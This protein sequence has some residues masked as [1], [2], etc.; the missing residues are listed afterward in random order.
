MENARLTRRVKLDEFNPDD[1]ELER[2]LSL[3]PRDGLSAAMRKRIAADL[4]SH[5]EVLVHIADYIPG[6][7]AEDIIRELNAR[8]RYLRAI[9]DRALV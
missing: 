8:V 1:P 9:A 4:R 5:A 3:P 7:H 2:R 6:M